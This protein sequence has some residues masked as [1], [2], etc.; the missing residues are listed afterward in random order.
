MSG[1]FLDATIKKLN[2]Q[3]KMMG[4]EL[5][6]TL[7]YISPE[8]QARLDEFNRTYVPPVLTRE[9]QLYEDFRDNKLDMETL[10]VDDLKLILKKAQKDV[11]EYY[12]HDCW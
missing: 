6:K 7:F 4:E 12:N 10:P 9:Q 5:D 3:L 1:E 8:E 2:E 11:L